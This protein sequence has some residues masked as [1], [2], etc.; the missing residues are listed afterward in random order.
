MTTECLEGSGE[1]HTR[2]GKI[3]IISLHHNTFLEQCTANRH[4]FDIGQICSLNAQRSLD[5][6]QRG[7]DPVLHGLWQTHI[8]APTSALLPHFPMQGNVSPLAHELSHPSI[9]AG[10]AIAPE[11]VRRLSV[12]TW[13]VMQMPVCAHQVLQNGI[14]CTIAR[15]SGATSH[16]VGICARG[17]GGNQNERLVVATVLFPEHVNGLVNPCISSNGQIRQRMIK[18]LTVHPL[19]D[20]GEKPGYRFFDAHF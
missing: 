12:I 4:D 17:I 16:T 8:H 20:D 5:N 1:Y 14:G 6:I 13:A 18:P 3:V 10:I 15:D 11:M 2:R 19:I 7:A 9:R